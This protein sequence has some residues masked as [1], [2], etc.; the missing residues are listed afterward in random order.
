LILLSWIRIRI[1]PTKIDADPCGSGSGSGSETLPPTHVHLTYICSTHLSVHTRTLFSNIYLIFLNIFDILNIFEK[2]DLFDILDIL[3]RYF[4][5][6]NRTIPRFFKNR[7]LT[8]KK[9][10]ETKN[11]SLSPYF[12]ELQSYSPGSK[13]KG[14]AFYHTFPTYVH[15][16]FAFL[17]L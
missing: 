3:C 1:Q 7:S 13:C 4:M 9:M 11:P 8:C 14:M 2:L 5:S 12:G 10:R 17:V 16:F 15:K 6:Q